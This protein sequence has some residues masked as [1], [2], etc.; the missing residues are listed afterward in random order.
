M[1]GNPM[2]SDPAAV[3]NRVA[4]AA[5]A[6]VFSVLGLA[7]ALSDHVVGFVQHEHRDPAG[8]WFVIGGPW[9]TNLMV[10]SRKALCVSAP[11]WWLWGVAGLAVAVP[12][13]GWR[14]R[15]WS[16]SAAR[17]MIVGDFLVWVL[18]AVAGLIVS[19]G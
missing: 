18:L 8:C 3:R 19:G 12:I 5:A 14:A 2:R 1:T 15:L 7:L 4:W 17:W 16:G 10:S 13:V 6:S 11:E 9:I